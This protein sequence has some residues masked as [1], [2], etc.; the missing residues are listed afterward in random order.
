MVEADES[1]DGVQGSAG[2]RLNGGLDYVLGWLVLK[3]LNT[4]FMDGYHKLLK[5]WSQKGN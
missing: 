5:R 3:L 2:T 1:P 4:K